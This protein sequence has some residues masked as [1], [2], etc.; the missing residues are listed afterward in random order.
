[1]RIGGS[2][3]KSQ[4]VNLR[5]I[6]TDS[7]SLPSSLPPSLPPSL[8]QDQID[9]ISKELSAATATITK[10]KVAIK[11][12]QRSVRLLTVNPSNRFPY[13]VVQEHEEVQREGPVTGG[14]GGG[15]RE[16]NK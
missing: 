9:R 1:M 2:R 12:A 15:D 4:Q 16:E 5:P 11:T 6:T 13:L 10:A 14:R 3:M 8:S 7:Y